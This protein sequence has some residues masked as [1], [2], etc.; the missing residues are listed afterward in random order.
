MTTIGM[1]LRFFACIYFYYIFVHTVTYIGY[2]LF[3]DTFSVNWTCLHVDC[4]I[5]A[6]PLNNKRMISQIVFNWMTA[7]NHGKWKESRKKKSQ[8]DLFF[9]IKAIKEQKWVKILHVGINF[10]V[11]VKYAQ[12]LKVLI[13]IYIKETL[14]QWNRS[15]FMTVIYIRITYE[16]H[17]WCAI[18]NHYHSQLKPITRNIFQTPQVPPYI[19]YISAIFLSSTGYWIYVYIVQCTLYIYNKNPPNKHISVQVAAS[20]FKIST[21]HFALYTRCI[22][23]DDDG[24]DRTTFVLVKWKHC[25]QWKINDFIFKCFIWEA[26]SHYAKINN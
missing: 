22:Y 19:K 1:I 4:W 16:R 24:D 10:R 5:I 7:I 6:T 2:D 11:R 3:Y 25:T 12:I 26:K 15:L 17:I 18:L 23:D 13:K 21:N 8:K 9:S 14:P 20:Q